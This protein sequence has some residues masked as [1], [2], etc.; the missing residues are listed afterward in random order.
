[1]LR[2]DGR[3][4]SGNLGGANLLDR[5]PLSNTV[6]CQH[7]HSCI[8]LLHAD[9]LTSMICYVVLTVQRAGWTVG[10]G[11]GEFCTSGRYPTHSCRAL[12][13]TRSGNARTLHV[14]KSARHCQIS[15][16]LLISTHL[17]HFCQFSHFPPACCTPLVP[18]CHL[19]NDHRL[20]QV[21]GTNCR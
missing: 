2:S 10:G 13:Q 15:L 5:H 20:N 16:P 4:W 11:S 19:L 7:V 21:P 18:L 12:C 9:R 3:F 6:P 14:V 8:F 1:M 17:C